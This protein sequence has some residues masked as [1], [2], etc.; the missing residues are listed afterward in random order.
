MIS[1]KDLFVNFVF[2]CQTK[3][4]Y[5]L[6][7]K[8]IYTLCINRKLELETMTHR[9]TTVRQ[10]N[11]LALFQKKTIEKNERE[12][13]FVDRRCLTLREREI[14]KRPLAQRKCNTG[15]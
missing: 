11:I 6:I 15:I 13:T 2:K 9:P 12:E 10:N 14:K 3:H 1:R 4:F 8:N 7:N 5:N